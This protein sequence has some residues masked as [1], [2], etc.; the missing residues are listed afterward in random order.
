MGRNETIKFDNVANSDNVTGTMVSKE[1]FP[2]H[3][4]SGY[5]FIVVSMELMT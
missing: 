3:A 1:N 4:F 5:R 2:V